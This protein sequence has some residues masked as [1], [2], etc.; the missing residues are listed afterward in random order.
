MVNG[1]KQIDNLPRY[2]VFSKSGKADLVVKTEEKK[3]VVFKHLPSGTSILCHPR[4][5]VSAIK[6]A[7]NYMAK[8]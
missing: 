2:K 4:N 7:R 6:C 1:W 5:K 8:N 3:W